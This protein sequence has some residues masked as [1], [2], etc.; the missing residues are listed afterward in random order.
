MHPPM[1]RLVL[2]LALFGAMY[3]ALAQFWST[4]LSH[5]VID[6]ATVQPAAWIASLCLGGGV[7]A[8]G[9]QLRS[10]QASLRVLFGCEGLD[11]LMLLFAAL[12]AAPVPWQRRLW[13][14][15]AGAA[16]VFVLN[17]IRILGLFFALRS[18]GGWFGTLHGL[19]APLALVFLVT[20]FYA[21]WL[22][23]AHEASPT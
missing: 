10:P 22:A 20:A 1:P 12:L 3:A 6:V 16:A 18:H 14:L 19:V 15:L 23:W 7:V 11:V 17:Q 5:W 13:G 4:G 21:A 8:D 9:A 2:F